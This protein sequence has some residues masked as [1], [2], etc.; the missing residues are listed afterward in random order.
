[1]RTYIKQLVNDLHV[2]GVGVYVCFCTNSW[3]QQQVHCFARVIVE[4]CN[5]SAADINLL[6][7]VLYNA[8]LSQVVS[9][10]CVLG[11]LPSA[12]GQ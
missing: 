9:S 10:S 6:K 5:T 2:A 3:L 1:M 8:K 4:T 12:R 11:E 7:T